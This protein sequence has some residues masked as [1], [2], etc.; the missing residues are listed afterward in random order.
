MTPLFAMLAAAGY[1]AATLLVW[2]GA[3]R[4]PAQWLVVVGLGFHATALLGEIFTGG[5]L[6]LGITEA[7]SLFSWQAAILLWALCLVQPVQVLG[8]AIFPLAAVAALAAAIW[9]TSVT[10]IPLADWKI[11]L[12]VVLSLF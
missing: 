11:Q 8:I 9:P 2:R 5:N 10:A 12:H 1:A 6:A 4:G 7:L 3:S